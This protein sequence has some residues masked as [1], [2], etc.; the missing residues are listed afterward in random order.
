MRPWKA[1]KDAEAIVGLKLQKRCA[2]L[3]KSFALCS[4]SVVSATPPSMR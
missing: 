2:E 1:D 3:F 4:L